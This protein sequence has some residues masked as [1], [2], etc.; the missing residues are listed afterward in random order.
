[1]KGPGKP[2]RLGVVSR[3]LGLAALLALV[4]FGTGCDPTAE[5]RPGLWLSGEVAEAPAGDWAFSDD[6]DLI[7][8]ES[9][10]VYGIPHSVTVVCFRYAGDLY[11]PSRGAVE[12]FWV[13]NV[14]RYPDVRLR[15][16]GRIYPARAEKVDLED[17]AVRAPLMAAIAAKY[18]DIGRDTQKNQ[19]MWFFRMTAGS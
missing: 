4:W 1:M 6:V 7:Q 18:P 15:I 17:P 12:K 16:A 10:T 13:S 14:L 2:A 8:L 3:G 19:D 9:E 11:V 5:G